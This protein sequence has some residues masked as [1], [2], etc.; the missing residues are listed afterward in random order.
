M[1]VTFGIMST[2]ENVPQLNAVIESIKALQIPQCEIIVTGSYRG[3]WAKVAVGVQHVLMDAWTPKKKNTV[4]KLAQFETLC[5]L[6][7]YYL[8]DSQW[9]THWKTFDEVVKWDVAL[10]PQYLNTGKRHFTDWVVYDHPTIPRYTS[11][12]YKDWSKTMYQYVS[13][14]YFL[15]KRSFLQQN[16]FNESL[17]PGDAEDVEWTL[18]IREKGRIVCNPLPIVYHNKAHRD[19]N[20]TGFPFEQSTH[21]VYHA[22]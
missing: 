1:N 9:Y 12:D 15:V 8:F 21:G 2:Y 3:E 13:G 11:L 22:Q 18:R 17:K 14:G 5:L 4:A 7:D 6:H 20:R 19:A 16:P 10:N